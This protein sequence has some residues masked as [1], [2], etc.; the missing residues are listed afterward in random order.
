MEATYEVGELVEVLRNPLDVQ[1]LSVP[2]QWVSAIVE[3]QPAK[4]RDLGFS[5]EHLVY[6]RVDGTLVARTLNNVRKVELS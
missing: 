3:P 1:Y 2:E 4:L 5:A 6:V